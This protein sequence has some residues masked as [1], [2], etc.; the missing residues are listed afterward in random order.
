[1]YSSQSSSSASAN[2]LVIPLVSSQQCAS[3]IQRLKPKRSTG[4]DTVSSI[5]LKAA[6]EHLCLPLST[7]INSAISQNQFPS[8]WKSAI[9]HPLHKAG[10]T[11]ICAN[12]RP[13][14]ILPAASK[15]MEMY[16]ADLLKA[17][18][19]HNNLLYTLQSGFRQ[20]HSTQSLLLRLT[21]SWYKSLDNGDYVGVVFLDISKAFDTVNHQLLLHKLRTQFRLS[22]SLCQLLQSYLHQR[23]QVVLAN[24]SRSDSGDIPSG[25]PQGSIL[26]PILFSMFIND[27]PAVVNSSITTALFADDST[28]SAPGINVATVESQIN[29]ALCA[30][31][32]WMRQNCLEVNRLKTKCMLIRSSRRSLP[33]LNI[34]FDGSPIDQV[35]TFKLLGVT[36]DDNLR[37][38]HHIDKIL[39]PILARTSIYYVD[40]QDFFLEKP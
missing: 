22:P 21:D 27:L 32:F 31:N 36:V 5:I 18:L 14:S 19:Q 10:P 24:G 3:L 30:V 6:P 37:W 7:I 11:D 4:C 28:F 13:I 17:H 34:V 38:S 9:V 8:L 39:K 1:M 23:N 26:G 40:S 35:R 33:P 15:V 20:G 16:V 29:S 2:D 25:V 12:Y